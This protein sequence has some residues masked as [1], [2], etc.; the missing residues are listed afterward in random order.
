MHCCYLKNG[1]NASDE[2]YRSISKLKRNAY[3]LAEYN[4]L[5]NNSVWELKLG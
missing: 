1:M 2:C 3:F 5:Y 4:Y